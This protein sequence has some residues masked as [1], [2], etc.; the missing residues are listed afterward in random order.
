[1]T[2]REV[3][4]MVLD[5]KQPPYVPWSFKFTKEPKEMLQKYFGVKD[6]DK[7]LGNHILQLGNDIGFFDQLDEIH[8]KDVFGVVWDRSIDKDIGNVCNCV[9]PEP[10]LD[11]YTF[12]NPL[13]PRYF[14]DINSEIEAKPDMFRVFQIGFSLYERAWTLRGIENLLMDFIINPD[15]VEQLFDAIVDY[16]IAQ[17]D[18]ALKYDIDAIYFGDDWGQQHGLIMGHELWSKLIFPR[19]KRM[20]DHVHA[21]GKYVMIH[22]CGD[23]DELFDDLVSIGLDSFNPFQPEVMDVYSLLPQYRG[24]LAFHGGLSMQRVLPFGT[25]EE[26]REE[27]QRLIELGAH[28]GYIFS[29]SHSVEGDTSLENILAFI[30]VAQSQP[31]YKNQQ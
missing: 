6:L 30:D 25:V 3:I 4:K 26:V 21:A 29:P 27:S 9:L 12:P 17:I 24:K 15:F 19:L 28:G 14:A 8:F 2:K 20:Y 5:G 7:V 11:G 10:T 31:N 23:V 16:N 1:M 13:D 18:E 22:S